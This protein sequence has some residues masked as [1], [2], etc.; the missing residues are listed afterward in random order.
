MATGA[1][2]SITR[3]PR[4]RRLVTGPR[5]TWVNSSDPSTHFTSRTLGL[6]R[7]GCLGSW[8]CKTLSRQTMLPARSSLW[9]PLTTPPRPA[10]E[11]DDAVRKSAVRRLPRPAGASAAWLQGFMVVL[12]SGQLALLLPGLGPLRLVVRMAV[13]G[14]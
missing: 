13:F 11:G 10:R 3:R 14:V 12:I 9:L 8:G 2:G 6:I 7:F 5:S 4:P 1:G